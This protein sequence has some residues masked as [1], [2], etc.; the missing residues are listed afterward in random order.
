MGKGIVAFLG[1]VACDSKS[2]QT[3][4]RQI[5]QVIG[6]K[7][8]TLY[9]GG[10]NG[11]MEY[12]AQG[13]AERGGE[14]VAVTMSNKEEW[15]SFNSYVSRALYLDD[16]GQRI[17]TFLTKADAVVAF[18]GGVGTLHE[19]TAAIWYAGNV[20]RIPIILVGARAAKFLQF[21]KDQKWI[22]HSPTRPTDFLSVAHTADELDSRLAAPDFSPGEAE[23][24]SINFLQRKLLDTALV[25]GRY[26]R[27]DGTVISPY[28]DPFQISEDPKTI[29]SAAIAIAANASVKTDAIVGV[30][31]GG[32]SLATLVAQVL[33]KPLALIRLKPKGY[34]AQSQLEGRVPHN[35]T[36]MLID[37]VVRTGET[38]LKVRAALEELGLRVEQV[39]C[40]MQRGEKGASLL[41]QYGI[42]LYRL[43]DLP[44]NAKKSERSS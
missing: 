44:D 7:A 36:V 17:N 23:K 38:I 32:V 24:I 30:A 3:L 42:T 39:A 35:S 40:I 25:R 2:E 43:F 5:G 15:G 37:D 41:T 18:A 19:V 29:H 12:V 10:Y 6:T 16:I 31:L 20:R 33:Q 21:L 9:H 8:L 14:V 13:V 26:T 1:G 34:G 4:A 22:Y 28:F 11:L 27:S